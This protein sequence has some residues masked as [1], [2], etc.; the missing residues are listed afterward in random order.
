MK[1]IKNNIIYRR[2]DTMDKSVEAVGTSGRIRVV[3]RC[4]EITHDV[5]IDILAEMSWP[6]LI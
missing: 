2:N 4:S 5:D 3:V 1:Y 6:I